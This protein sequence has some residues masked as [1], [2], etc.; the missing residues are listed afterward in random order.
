MLFI[1]VTSRVR[2]SLS[3]FIIEE[4]KDSPKSLFSIFFK[5]AFIVRSN[6][7]IR[8]VMFF[9]TIRDSI[10]CFDTISDTL[11]VDCI[12]KEPYITRFVWSFG[13]HF[14]SLHFF[15]YGTRTF[16][17]RQTVFFS[18]HQGFFIRKNKIH[19]EI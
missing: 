19:Q 3:A 17:L 12:L 5:L 15:I 4:L 16:S 2:S 8:C 1:A 10:F 7:C 9:G 6:G 11:A 13:G 14:S 18:L